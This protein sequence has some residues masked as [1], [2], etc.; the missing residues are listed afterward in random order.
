MSKVSVELHLFDKIV[1]TSYYEAFLEKD[2]P[3]IE[4][5][6]FFLQKID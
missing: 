3:K 4:N 1:M 6:F 5:L 2:F